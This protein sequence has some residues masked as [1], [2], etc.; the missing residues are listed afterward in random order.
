MSG[1]R[2]AIK[3]VFRIW[4]KYMNK[5]DTRD[6]FLQKVPMLGGCTKLER[7]V[8]KEAL[9]N[10]TLKKDK[11]LFKQDEKGHS[12]FIVKKGVIGAYTIAPDGSKREIARFS[13]GQSFGEMAIIESMPRSTTCYAVTDSELLILE[14]EDLYQFIWNYPVIGIKI[15]KNKL[16]NMIS[17]L[18]DANNFLTHMV[19]WGEKARY[20]AITDKLTKLYNRRFFEEAMRTNISKS[21]HKNIRFCILLCDLDHFH[22]INSRFGMETGDEILRFTAGIFKSSFKKNMIISRLGGDEFAVLMPDANL[23]K[24]LKTAEQFRSK[25]EKS[26]FTI[27]GNKII[28]E[29]I[30]ASI[31]VT[32]CPMHGKTIE[33]LMETADI[34]LYEVKKK[35]RNN[36][37]SA[38]N[39]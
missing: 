24:A 31:S 9:K 33:E 12:I 8:I 13:S 23:D 26:K 2:E 16:Q 28:K 25:L 39:I 3:S 10:I 4:N 32:E 34:T 17:W 38:V 18:S 30:T 22:S 37:M 11:I 15:L 35:G 20:K 7:K 19:M 6:S 27:L 14:A 5:E 36:V 29:N 1:K 21:V